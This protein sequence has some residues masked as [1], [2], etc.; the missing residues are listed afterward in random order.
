M[1]FDAPRQDT[2]YTEALCRIARTQRELLECHF[3]WKGRYRIEE[4]SGGFFRR[5][6]PAQ[7]RYEEL[8]NRLESQRKEAA[9]L[10]RT[11]DQGIAW[12][13][14]PWEQVETGL[15]YDLEEDDDLGDWRFKRTWETSQTQGQI[16]LFL[17]EE[18]HYSNFSHST[19]FETGIISDYS[20]AEINSRLQEFEDR[21]NR[22]E[23][24]TMA[25]TPEGPVRSA[26]T[27]A[28]YS[29]AADYIMSAEHMNR[30]YD[31][32]R[33]LERS[34]YT[35][36]ET[37]TLTVHSHS[38]HYEAV[39]SVAGFCIEHG[40]LVMLDL[41]NY[42]LSAGRGDVP[43]DM[44]QF[45]ASRDAAVGCA[46]YLADHDIVSKVPMGLFGRGVKSAAATYAEARRQA[47][48]YTC[49]ADKMEI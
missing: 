41:A 19:S 8:L 45:Y 33:D 31:A 39:Y 6:N 47:E 13:K 32:R 22:Y 48:I 7:Q 23:W 1:F 42:R 9:R 43:E 12:W 36:T 20:Q 14:I 2:A 35:E 49:L 29:S 26:H 34:L 10:Q 16:L 17:H 44:V 4:S 27:G 15:I 18:G 28:I 40:R 38:R 5:K 25:F 46:A 21:A 37:T 3:D 30:R 24:S 11:Y